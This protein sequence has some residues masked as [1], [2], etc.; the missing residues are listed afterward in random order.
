MSKADLSMETRTAAA[1]SAVGSIRTIV[2]RPGEEGMSDGAS[3]ATLSPSKKA[4]PMKTPGAHSV[5]S[6][7]KYNNSREMNMLKEV[8]YKTVLSVIRNIENKLELSSEVY[9]MM[10]EASKRD[11]KI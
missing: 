8:D 5:A 2:E 4:P 7:V 3:V 9:D 1:Q 10:I 6:S 11:Y